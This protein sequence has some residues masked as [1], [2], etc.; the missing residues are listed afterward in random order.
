[1]TQPTTA[2]VTGATGFLGRR[3]V[4]LLL[5]EGLKVTCLVRDPARQASALPPGVGTLRGDITDR[6][7]IDATIGGHEL[8]F[9]LAGWLEIGLSERERPRMRAVN[10]T[11]TENV[12]ESAWKAG[13][14]RIVFCCSVGALGSSGP[15]GRVGDET[16]PH[17]GKFPNYYLQTKYDGHQIAKRLSAQGAPIISVLPEPAYGPGDTKF[18]GRQIWRTM[19]G[20]NTSIPDLPGIFGYVHGDDLVRGTRLAAEKGRPGESYILAGPLLT[21]AQFYE[22]VARHLG[23]PAPQGRVPLKA[24]HAL[25]WTYHHVPGGKLLTKGMTVDRESIAMIESNWAYSA[26]KARDELG[27]QARTLDEGLPETIAWVKAHPEVFE[28]LEA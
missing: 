21:L 22:T 27:W 18:V 15:P 19:K 17:S 3:L 11:G 14:S 26:Q 1:M 2:Y 13:A 25:S 6:K 12:L 24:L 23:V 16:H 4:P 5:D 10:V 8:V 9:H 28:G 7:R 20:L